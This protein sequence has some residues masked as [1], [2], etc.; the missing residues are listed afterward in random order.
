MKQV[1]TENAPAALGPYSQG[2]V[3]DNFLFT[4]GQIGID[5]ATGHLV[6]GGLTAQAEQVMKNLSAIL[7]EAG[8]STDKIVKTTCF[9]ADVNDF[10]AFNQVYAKYIKQK[11]ARSCFAVKDIPTG[12]LC[13]VEVIAYLK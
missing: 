10:S 8:T 12:A 1:H 3:A 6:E 13:E 11:P 4:S 9:L 2:I 5:P 7:E